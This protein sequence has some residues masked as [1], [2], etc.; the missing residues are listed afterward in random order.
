MFEAPWTT[1]QVASP[2]GSANDAPMS[3]TRWNA[4]QP[5]IRRALRRAG[6]V[7]SRRANA[8]R[9]ARSVRTKPFPRYPSGPGRVDGVIVAAGDIGTLGFGPFSQRAGFID[10]PVRLRLQS[11][12]RP[13]RNAGRRIVEEEFGGSVGSD[14]PHPNA[15]VGELGGLEFDLGF[16]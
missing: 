1:A 8:R 10:E 4:D 3:F 12:H 15:E 16:V 14:H 2:E 9:R 13:V 5:E 11:F 7:G 6:W